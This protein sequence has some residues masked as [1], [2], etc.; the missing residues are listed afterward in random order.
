MGGKKAILAL[1][2]IVATLAAAVPASAFWFIPNPLGFACYARFDL[3]A[4]STIQVQRG[5][6]TT[7]NA[8]VYNMR[9]GLNGA[10]LKLNDMP[11]EWYE[12]RPAIIG[13]MAPM[14]NHTYMVTLNIPKNATEKT[15][16]TQYKFR[17]L[18]YGVSWHRTFYK[19]NLTISVR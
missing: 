3:E 10:V 9:C 2:V 1:A 6:N 14:R 11:S 19:G 7:F 18:E 17:G 4:P 16:K 5:I 13:G 15:Y 12:A 8:T